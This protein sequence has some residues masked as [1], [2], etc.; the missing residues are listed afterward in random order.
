MYNVVFQKSIAAAE[1]Q[2]A[3]PSVD[4][5][6]MEQYIDLIVLILRTMSVPLLWLKHAVFLGN[7]DFLLLPVTALLTS[8]LIL[9]IGMGRALALECSVVQEMRKAGSCQ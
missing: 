8:F 4:L 3:G 9:S 2:F 5:G 6:N 1:N 7:V